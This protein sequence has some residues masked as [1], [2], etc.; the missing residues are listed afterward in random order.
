MGPHS[1]PSGERRSGVGKGKHKKVQHCT[2]RGETDQW[3][4]CTGGDR[5]LRWGGGGTVLTTDHPLLRRRRIRST[6]LD[7]T[8]TRRLTRHQTPTPPPSVL[9][10]RDVW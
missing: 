9:Q 3:G 4:E 6:P 1:S 7:L 2:A 10:G 8:P 5:S